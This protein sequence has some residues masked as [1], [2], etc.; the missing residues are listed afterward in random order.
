[1]KQKIKGTGH[2]VV[3]GDITI[4]TS[5]SKASFYRRIY[6]AYLIDSGINTPK[7]LLDATKMP[8]RT[9]QDTLA[10]LGEVGIQA[11]R[12]GGTK[13]LTY[14]IVNWGAINKDWIENNL[15]HVIDVLE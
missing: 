14:Q 6:V 3:N 4:N 7:E 12:S 15:Q 2:L 10:A 9:L 1:M 8:R 13:N 11:E 5:R